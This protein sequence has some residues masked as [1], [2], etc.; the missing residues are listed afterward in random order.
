MGTIDGNCQDSCEYESGDIFTAGEKTDTNS[1]SADDVS[2]VDEELKA[3]VERQHDRSRSKSRS[4]L[5][6]K[7]H[8]LSRSTSTP[9][10]RHNPVLGI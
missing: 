7:W 5:S 3:L 10:H 8:T 2:D 1:S 6:D 9:K 4:A